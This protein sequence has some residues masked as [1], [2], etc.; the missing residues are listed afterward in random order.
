MA[1]FSHNCCVY[2]VI[3]SVMIQVGDVSERLWVYTTP[4]GDRAELCNFRWYGGNRLITRRGLPISRYGLDTSHPCVPV[5]QRLTKGLARHPVP[6]M[7]LARLAVRTGWQG[8]ACWASSK[9]LVLA[10]VR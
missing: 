1:D 6:I 4:G 9:G 7:L 8:R 5:L 2:I 3:F 10:S